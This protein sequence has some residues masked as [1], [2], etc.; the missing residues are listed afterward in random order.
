MS[1]DDTLVPLVDREPQY[2]AVNSERLFDGRTEEDSQYCLAGALIGAGR[3]VPIRLN[4]AKRG[5][6]SVA[7]VVR[8]PWEFLSSYKVCLSPG[9]QGWEPGCTGPQGDD[10]STTSG[11]ARPSCP[12]V[13]GTGGGPDGLSEGQT[14]CPF[15]VGSVFEASLLHEIARILGARLGD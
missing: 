3:T 6:Q 2:A 15:S 13:R 14:V 9:C 11:G 7:S 1:I 5:L 10:V 12:H 8:R 4:K